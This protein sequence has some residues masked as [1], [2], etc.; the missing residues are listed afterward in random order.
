ML[1]LDA[2]CGRRY[3]CA[4][5]CVHEGVRMLTGACTL[6]ISPRHPFDVETASSDYK[7]VLNSWL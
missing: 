2:A 5:V 7:D 1:G 6:L 3:V 4:G